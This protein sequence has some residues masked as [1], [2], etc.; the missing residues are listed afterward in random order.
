MQHDMSLY[1]D[2]EHSNTWAKNANALSR[3]ASSS[4]RYKCW[5]PSFWSDYTL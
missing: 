4:I 2:L 3:K 1:K 5:Q